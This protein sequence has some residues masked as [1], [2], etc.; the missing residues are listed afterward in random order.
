MIYLLLFIEFFKIGLFTFGGGYAMIPLVKETVL[1]NGWLSE[2]LFYEFLGI[3]ESTPGPIAINMATYVG[4]TQGNFLGA[5]CATLGVV[6]PSFI[7]ILIIAALLSKLMENKHVKYALTGIKYVVVGLI[8]ATGIT[9]IIKCLGFASIN[10]F[11]VNYSSIIILSIIS[12]IYAFVRFVY[13]K[14]EIPV[15]VLIIMGAVLGII[16]NKVILI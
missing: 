4:T 13:P 3:C 9:L 11:V 15:I 6:L 8:I 14:K 12:I 10:S 2:E 1:K 5:L 7:I 16:F